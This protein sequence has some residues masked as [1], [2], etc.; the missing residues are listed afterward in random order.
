MPCSLAGRVAELEAEKED[1]AQAVS[2][3]SCRGDIPL[4]E[5]LFGD[6]T[7]MGEKVVHGNL[8]DADPVIATDLLWGKG[9]HVH[10]RL[11]FRQLEAKDVACGE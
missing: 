2:G 1:A 8:H 4:V 7:E 6:R 10:E 3:A 9:C 11:L 5:R